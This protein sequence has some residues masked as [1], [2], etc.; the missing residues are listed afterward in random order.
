MTQ[1]NIDIKWEDIK[2]LI[3]AKVSLHYVDYRDS[4]DEHTKL[5]ER[6]IKDGNYDALSEEV[7]EWDID[8]HSGLDY[9]RDELKADIEKKFDIEDASDIMEQFY[10]EIRETIE[11][12]D[13]SDLINDLLR[14]TSKQTMFYDTGYEMESESW[15]WSAAR[16][17]LERFLIK[18]HLGIVSDNTKHNWDEAID[19]MIAQASYGGQLVI[20]FYDDVEDYIKTEDVKTISF[21][22]FSLAII[23]T[24]NGSG[25]NTELIGAKTT[26]PFTSENLYLCKNINYSYTFS[27]CGMSDNWCDN[28]IVEFGKEVAEELPALPTSSLA[29]T[30]A[31]DKEYDATYRAGSCTPGDMNI[32]RHRRTTYINN[33]PCGTKCLDCST[34]FID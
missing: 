27:V 10:D 15:S 20:Y 12:R 3:P 11:D 25:D 8:D 23:N 31:K 29:Q 34:F 6:C 33:Y 28:T 21:R 19:M 18:K 13:D 2:A 24:G 22:N 14:N 1:E 16:I 26:L 32:S 7:W 5:L 30:Q 4:L 9:V 17:R